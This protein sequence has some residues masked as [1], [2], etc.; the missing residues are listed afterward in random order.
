MLYIIIYLYICMYI[1]VHIC[2]YILYIYISMYVCVYIS[3]D[4]GVRK[5]RGIARGGRTRDLLP[6]H[7]CGQ[8]AAAG[9]A[10]AADCC[11]HAAYR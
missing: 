6:A 5:Q 9:G 11:G 4:I 7:V 10:D 1:Y 2:I 8:Q 3:C